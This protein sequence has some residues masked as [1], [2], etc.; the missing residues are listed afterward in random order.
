MTGPRGDNLDAISLEIYWNRLLAIC[1]EAVTGLI[2]TTF[3]TIVRESRDCVSV[4]L[5][6]DGDLIA[7]NRGSVPAFVGC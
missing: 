3:S 2:R 4:V 7:E 5:D 6:V 1:D